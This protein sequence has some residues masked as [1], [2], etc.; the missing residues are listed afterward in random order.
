LRRLLAAATG[1]DGRQRM[2]GEMAVVRTDGRP[3]ITVLVTPIGPTTTLNNLAPVSAALVLVH[4][5]ARQLAHPSKRLRARFG[6][7]QAETALAHALLDGK[8]L[9]E[10]ATER[11]VSIETVR[12]QLRALFRKTGVSR[13][14]DLM[15]LLLAVPQQPPTA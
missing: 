12:T 3:P 2:G 14:A 1:A 13:Q 7:T 4:D 8:R 5:P 9:A 6:L 15:R 10:I 11:G